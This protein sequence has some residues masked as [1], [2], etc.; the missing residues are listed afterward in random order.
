MLCALPFFG[1]ENQSTFNWLKV[2][3]FHPSSSIFISFSYYPL[4]LN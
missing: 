3:V 4:N 1:V 2:L